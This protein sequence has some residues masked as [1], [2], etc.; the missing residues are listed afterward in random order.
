MLAHTQALGHV[1]T[2]KS[3]IQLADIILELSASTATFQILLTREQ[4]PDLEKPDVLL[5]PHQ[6]PA[7][8][9]M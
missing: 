2:L 6:F 4:L 5:L 9:G 8:T 7:S 1:Y 3:N